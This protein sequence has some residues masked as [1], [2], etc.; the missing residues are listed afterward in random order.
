MK[1]ITALLLAVLM[2]AGS[3][4]CGQKNAETSAA[5]AAPTA[6]HSAADTPEAAEVEQDVPAYPIKE[7]ERFYLEYEGEQLIPGEIY[8]QSRFPDLAD[9]ETTPD[10]RT[11]GS[12]TTYTYSGLTLQT[13]ILTDQEEGVQSEPFINSLEIKDSSVATPE[14]ITLGST[15]EALMEAY[16]GGFTESFGAYVY[17]A[18]D[19]CLYAYPDEAGETIRYLIISLSEE[20]LGKRLADFLAANEEAPEEEM[21]F[22]YDGAE[23]YSGIRFEGLNARYFRNIRAYRL[24]R[25]TIASDVRA[26]DEFGNELQVEYSISY[27]S[28]VKSCQWGPGLVTVTAT[29]AQGHT[30]K[31][32]FNFF[33]ESYSNKDKVII[34]EMAENVGDDLVEIKNYVR[35][36]FRYVS[37]YAGRN[38]I[39]ATYK[40]GSGNCYSYARVLQSLLEYKGYHAVVIWATG[41]KHNWVLVET[42]DG[43][44]HLDATRGPRFPETEGLQTDF[45]RAATHKN[46]PWNTKLF[47]AA[48]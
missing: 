27:G 2:L 19:C 8:S 40:N 35:N 34:E 12:T 16:G 4:G 25:D 32:W 5:I 3:A 18:G 31:Q 9:P 14:G 17:T 6:E 24:G 38:V 39:S 23:N 1:R 28:L 29:D 42:E 11:D 7:F 43:W 47:P 33:I 13:A 20:A 46:R 26:F 21:V 44:R 41:A 22:D 45:E 37:H 48:R 30:A 15:V 10:C 36:S